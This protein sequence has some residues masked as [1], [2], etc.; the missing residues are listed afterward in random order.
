MH[1]RGQKA[2]M[3]KR[4]LLLAAAGAPVGKLQMMGDAGSAYH[5][6]QSGTLRLGPKTVLARFGETEARAP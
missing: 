1:A 5:P 6:G 4:F 2:G 3:L